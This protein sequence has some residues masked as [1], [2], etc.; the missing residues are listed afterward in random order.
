MSLP[1]W[2]WAAAGGRA[3]VSRAAGLQPE[4]LRAIARAGPNPSCR[5]GVGRARGQSIVELALI[6]PILLLLVAAA[7]DLGRVFYSQ[8]TISNAA[9]EGALEAAKNPDSFQ[10]GAACDATTNRVMCRVVNESTG[11][12]IT[13][14]PADVAMACA[15]SPCPATPVLGNMVEVTVDAD[16]ELIT[17]ILSSFI[18]GGGL[19]LTSTATAQIAVVPPTSGAVATPTPAPTPTPTGTGP[20]PTATPTPT[21]TG[22]GGAPTPPPFCPVPQASFSYEPTIGIKKKRTDVAFTSTSTNM[23]S[24]SLPGCGPF[25]FSWNFGDGSGASSDPNP[26][27]QWEQQGTD[28]VQLWVSN[29]PGAGHSTWSRVSMVLHP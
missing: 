5:S 15:P 17:P 29:L 3:I 2:P 18:G 25:I 23:D 12:F 6:L 19:T 13:V 28:V 8:I 11:S 21:P 22:T 14:R 24:V 10:S 1:P 16:F 7:I 20:A 27:F 26:V 9:R 4:C